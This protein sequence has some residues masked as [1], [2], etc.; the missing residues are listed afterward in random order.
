M[1]PTMAGKGPLQSYWGDLADAGGQAL[2]DMV[3][4]ASPSVFR[5]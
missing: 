3:A 4:C 2:G 1:L 5:I